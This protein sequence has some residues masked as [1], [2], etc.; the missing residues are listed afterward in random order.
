MGTSIEQT[1]D[2]AL[3]IHPNPTNGLLIARMT[4]ND[5][6]SGMLRVRS[7]DGRMVLE[8]RMTAPEV[9]MDVQG[10]ANGAYL[11]ELLNDNGL[12]AVVRFVK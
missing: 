10:L 5:L 8:Q 6:R 7:M 4:G 11:M 1:F 9:R 3:P 12:R 2:V